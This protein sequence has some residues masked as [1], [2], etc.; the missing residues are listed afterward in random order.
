MACNDSNLQTPHKNEHVFASWTDCSLKYIICSAVF[1]KKHNPARA[2]HDAC[3]NNNKN[4]IADSVRHVRLLSRTSI[5][6]PEPFSSHSQSCV[7]T[8]KCVYHVSVSSACASERRL[9]DRLWLDWCP[10]PDESEILMCQQGWIMHGPP[11]PLLSSSLLHL[12]SLVVRFSFHRSC[13]I[14]RHLHRLPPPSPHPH[15][16]LSSPYAKDAIISPPWLL[17]QPHCPLANP[18]PHLCS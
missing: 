6:N 13:H 16:F 2:Y 9:Q 8:C 4:K 17:L 3:F 1:W 11:L 5:V 12:L 10:S 7:I 15:P 18:T 14:W